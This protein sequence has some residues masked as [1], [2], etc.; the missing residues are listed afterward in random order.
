MLSLFVLRNSIKEARG[1][2]I[3]GIVSAQL[4]ATEDDEPSKPQD[5]L[6]AWIKMWI[7]KEEKR[8][9]A[10]KMKR[11]KREGM[12]KG[13]WSLGRPPF[14]YQYDKTANRWDFQSEEK[15]FTC[16]WPKSSSWRSGR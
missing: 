2:T 6:V 12:R 5:E 3:E 7:A 16:G 11:G 4:G 9:I 10:R 13:K 14:G 15:N 8:E 1:E